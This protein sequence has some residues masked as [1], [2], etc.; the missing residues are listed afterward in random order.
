MK[1]MSKAHK[2]WCQRTED[3]LNVVEKA[4][5]DLLSVVGE[6]SRQIVVLE[7]QTRETRKPV[8][9][10]TCLEDFTPDNPL[11]E[12]DPAKINLAMAMKED[13]K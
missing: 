9:D 12:T 4:F 10:A 6:L 7:Q 2:A 5:T 8:F 3:R 11:I 1:T 13:E